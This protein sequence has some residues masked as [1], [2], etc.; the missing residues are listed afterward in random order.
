MKKSAVRGYANE[1]LLLCVR[2]TEN[3]EFLHKYAK[4][5]KQFE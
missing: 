1:L 4:V 5:S 2:C 3:L